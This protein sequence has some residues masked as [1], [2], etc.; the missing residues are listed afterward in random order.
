MEHYSSE[1]VDTSLSGTESN[2]EVPPMLSIPNQLEGAYL[3]QDVMLECYCEAYPAS[4]N[5]WTTEAGDMIISDAARAGDKYETTSITN[6]YTKHMKLKIRNVGPKDFGTYRCVAKNSLGE[7]DGNIKLDE[8]PAPKSA[9]SIEEEVVNRSLDGKRRNNKIDSNAL[10]DYGVEEWRDGA[11]RNPP[12]AYHNSAGAL[13]QHNLL[14]NVIHGIKMQ[15]F[16]IFRRL[17]SYL[18]EAAITMKTVLPTAPTGAAPVPATTSTTTTTTTIRKTIAITMSTKMM[19]STTKTTV[20]IIANTTKPTTTATTRTIT[21]TIAT[22]TLR[23]MFIRITITT[24]YK[25]SA[26]L[27]LLPVYVQATICRAT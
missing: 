26:I 3:G 5:Y 18:V 4:I 25:L 12:G 9:I 8:L 1:L 6:G 27:S 19:A 20:T 7:T 11:V 22:T 10:P 15:S 13:A 23:T 24:C 2:D 16:G 21:R 14:G 17:S